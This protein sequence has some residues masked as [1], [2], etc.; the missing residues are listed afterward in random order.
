MVRRGSANQ[1]FA[2]I[3]DQPADRPTRIV[4]Q[5]VADGASVIANLDIAINDAFGAAA[6]L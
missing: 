2:G 3:D 6:W 4:E 5:E 1:P